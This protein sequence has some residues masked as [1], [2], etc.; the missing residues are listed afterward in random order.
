MAKLSALVIPAVID[1]SGVDKGISQIKN[2]LSKVRG[3]GGGGGIGGGGAGFSSGVTPY[4]GHLSD[5]GSGIAA[6]M[7]AAFGSRVASRTESNLVR[8]RSSGMIG[9]NI[10]MTAGYRRRYGSNIMT[11]GGVGDAESSPEFTSSIWKT[12]RAD[13]R[14]GYR[15]SRVRDINSL[16]DYRDSL[17][18]AN[19]RRASYLIQKRLEPFRKF[20]RGT[21]DML[22]SIDIA[23]KGLFGAISAGAA[24]EFFD[25][26]NQKSRFS[27]TAEFAGN[28]N[29]QAMVALRRQAFRPENQFMSLFQSIDVGAQ[30]A[31]GRHGG[32]TNLR[33]MGN[34]LGGAVQ[35]FG[36]VLG[37]ASEG[38]I[39][40]AGK[41]MGGSN[42][43]AT[44]AY[45]EGME[46]V[47]GGMILSV[48]NAFKRLFS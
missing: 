43:I 44:Q 40:M 41:L 15:Q 29:Y 6:A 28:E 32:Q 7:G 22:G 46:A 9:R 5:V 17:A 31:R 25:P 45:T 11:F 37:T 13:A 38:P 19:R 26:K 3:G 18:I 4:G 34:M 23:N 1:T 39:A 27:N 48:E 8:H 12:T 30:K 35:G 42:D 16:A 47:V 21:G 20:T 2:K 36:E 14:A 33:N 10:P 24:Y